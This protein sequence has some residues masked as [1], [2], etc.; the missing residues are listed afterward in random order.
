MPTRNR[1]RRLAAWLLSAALVVPALVATPQAR[2]A[3]PIR[4]RVMTFNIEYGGTVVDFAKIVAAARRAH[5]DVIGFEESYGRLPRLARALG[6]DYL[7]GRT[8]VVS[9]FPLVDAP[10]ADGRYTLVQLAPGA[11]AAVANDHLPSGPYGPRHILDGETRRQALRTERRVRVPVIRSILT[12]LEPVVAAGIP[13]FLVG[14]FNTPSAHDWTRSM[15]GER[16]Q[17]R[18]A[19]RWPVS[20]LVERAGFVDSYRAVFPDPLAH[21][22]LTWPADRPRSPDSWNPRRDAPEDRIDYVYAAGPVTPIDSEIVGE[23]GHPGV[24]VGVHPWG[25]D[26]RAVVS[27]FDVTQ[28]APPVLVSPGSRLVD[29]GSDLPVTYHA[30]GNPG[31]RVVVVP[32]GGD[33]TTDALASQATPSGAPIDGTLTFPTDTFTPGGYDTVL[34]GAADAELARASFWTKA[35]GSGPVVDTTMW[36]VAPGHAITVLWH[37]APGFRFDWVGIFPRGGDPA[38]DAYYGWAYTAATVDGRVRLD[39]DQLHPWPLPKGRYTVALAID[40]SY[41]GLASADFVVG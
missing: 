36:K 24:D 35:P 21:P 18:F 19:M 7:D 26:H 13:T 20:R 41:R 37:A 11:V 30:P 5:A 23:R 38:H 8:D 34:V 29:V 25:S 33:P 17:I 28:V 12:D 6:W 22:G 9:R 15:V 4:L 39:R 10:G 3:A 1:R 31:E 27:T 32:R 2:A 14:D 16:P 40:D